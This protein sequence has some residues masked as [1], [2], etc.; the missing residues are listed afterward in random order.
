MA[1]HRPS[2][3]TNDTSS[4]RS[5]Q[6]A[7]LAEQAKMASIG[8]SNLRVA[9][10]HSLVVVDAMRSVAEQSINSLSQIS[11]EAEEMRDPVSPQASSSNE[12]PQ[13]QEDSP[14][15]PS[16]QPSS[17]LG[18]Q[19]ASSSAASKLTDGEVSPTAMVDP[20]D[21]AQPMVASELAWQEVVTSRDFLPSASHLAQM[22]RAQQQDRKAWA[23]QALEQQRRRWTMNHHDTERPAISQLKQRH[24]DETVATAGK[25]RPN[26]QDESNQD[27]S[28]GERQ[29]KKRR[30][31]ESQEE[32]RKKDRRVSF[33]TGTAGGLVD[34][35]DEMEDAETLS[36]SSSPAPRA[37]KAGDASDASTVAEPEVEDGALVRSSARRSLSAEARPQLLENVLTSFASLLESRQEACA[38]L[39]E[40]AKHGNEIVEAAAA[41]SASR[42]NSRAC[43]RASSPKASKP[44]GSGLLSTNALDSSALDTDTSDEEGDETVGDDSLE[45]VEAASTVSSSSLREGDIAERSPEQQGTDSPAAQKPEQ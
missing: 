15:T 30:L 24:S 27:T 26:G 43:S 23:G 17:R 45:S 32:R 14:S 1:L 2:L 10:A 9:R 33:A 6:L 28:R 18:M 3:P 11:R 38:G 41:V 29:H 22:F 37:S 42:A 13:P 35:D 36:G 44:P 34:A 12:L 40:L 8:T 19:I 39:A 16:R 31:A 7:L 5:A 20:S 21:S 4:V 25:R